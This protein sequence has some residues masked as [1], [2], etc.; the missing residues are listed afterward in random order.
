MHNPVLDSMPRV[1]TDDWPNLTDEEFDPILDKIEAND[2]PVRL[3]KDGKDL[4]GVLVPIGYWERMM[5]AMPPEHHSDPVEAEADR[6]FRETFRS[7]RGA[8][9]DVPEIDV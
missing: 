1:A 5:A 4:R 9:K 6:R 3:T 2:V 7:L 8:L